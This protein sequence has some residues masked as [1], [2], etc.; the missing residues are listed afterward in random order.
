MR[1]WLIVSALLAALSGCRCC[2]DRITESC[3]PAA[4]QCDAQ[5]AKE[6]EVHAPR[7]RIVVEMPNRTTTCQAPCPPA[8]PAQAAP[9]QAPPPAAPAAPTPVM[10]LGQVPAA[11]GRMFGIGFMTMPITGPPATPVP[12]PNLATAPQAPPTTASMS[13]SGSMTVTQALMMLIASGALSQAQVDEILRI[14]RPTIAATSP[15][16][17]GMPGQLQPQQLASLLAALAAANPASGSSAATP[18]PTGTASSAGSLSAADSASEVLSQ[19]LPG[20]DSV[21]T[22]PSPSAQ[23][24]SSLELQLRQAEQRLR[25]LRH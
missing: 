21:P 2:L 7:P 10:A 25:E 12:G 16:Q 23:S 17:P 13:I 5:E 3:Q 6:V 19:R 9:C 24:L 4:P 22:A 14:L 8:A 20:A 15:A 11:T 18:T 1:S